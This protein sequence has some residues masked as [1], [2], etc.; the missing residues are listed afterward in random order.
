M[1]GVYLTIQYILA[2]SVI[3]CDFYILWHVCQDIEGFCFYFATIQLIFNSHPEF[4]LLFC[5]NR[6]SLCLGE[7]TSFRYL[8]CLN[9]SESASEGFAIFLFFGCLTARLLNCS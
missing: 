5:S 3:I 2:M 4:S 9:N 8:Q 6:L 1:M 7:V